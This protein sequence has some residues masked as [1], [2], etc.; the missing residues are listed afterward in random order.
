MDCSV[1]N[2]TL[3]RYFSP[4]VALL[5]CLVAL[6][7]SCDK[8]LN[9]VSERQ[10]LKKL[11]AE[12]LELINA[13]N[14][15]SLDLLRS[16]Y[17]LEQKD[18]FLVS[19]VG[20]GMTIG[21]IYNGVGLKEK[22]QIQQVMGTQSLVG[23]EINK[24]YNDLLSFI[25]MSNNQLDITCANSL[26]FP[27]KLHVDENYR[28]MMM[29]Y[30]DAEVSEINFGKATSIEV[31]NSWGHYKTEGHFE[32]LLDKAPGQNTDLLL[33]NAFGLTT[34]WNQQTNAFLA[35][36]PFQSL[37]GKI[38]NIETYNLNAMNVRLEQTEDLTYLEIPLQSNQ[39]QLTL[40]MPRQ[41]NDFYP[42]LDQLDAL[43]LSDMEASSLDFKA[44][45]SL[46]KI[47]FYTDK[48]MKPILAKLGMQDIFN[49]SADFSPS[50]EEAH[51]IISTID[52]KARFQLTTEA[53][54]PLSEP[55]FTD[56]SLSA[57]LI[58]RP[59]VY[60][61]KDRYTKTILFAGYYL[62]PVE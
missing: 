8:E 1:E 45:I 2:R 43:G 22:E 20:V 46:P 60:L 7:S 47:D 17:Q 54:I 37:H 58:N 27:G 39:F 25:Q 3:Y 50:F 9:E 12:D 49:V 44:N 23:T 57:V 33:M 32:S 41:G 10:V 52:H 56:A 53:Q 31:I 42:M 16:A 62:Q 14:V 61:V 15:F 24:S 5:L 59:F 55:G 48:S 21:M 26:W 19:P 4:T 11:S 38:T 40:L 18:N 6:L 13:S 36:R 30:Y 34:T 29:A 51:R 35:R 28:T